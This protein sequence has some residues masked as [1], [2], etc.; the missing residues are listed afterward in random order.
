MTA[1]LNLGMLLIL[2]L[3][4]GIKVSDILVQNSVQISI[5]RIF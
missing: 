5:M 4:F 1:Q 2:T 3:K